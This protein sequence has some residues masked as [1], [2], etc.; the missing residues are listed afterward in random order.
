VLS[1][2]CGAHHRLLDDLGLKGGAGPYSDTFNKISF[3]H[4]L[5][6]TFMGIETISSSGP[7]DHDRDRATKTSSPLHPQHHHNNSI[8]SWQRHSALRSPC[9]SLAIAPSPSPHN[10]I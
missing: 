1:A 9:P 7:S 6:S 2:T 5:F 10:W 8:D 3:E 4:D